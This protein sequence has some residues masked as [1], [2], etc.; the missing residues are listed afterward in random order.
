MIAIGARGGP[1]TSS[2]GEQ[3]MSDM[4]TIAVI[5][6]T[7]AQGGGLVR[8]ILGDPARRFA[9]RAITRNTDSEKAG[10]LHAAG[11]EVVGGDA[12]DPASLERAF[13]GAYGAFLVTNLWEQF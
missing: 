12:D 7:G 6:S 11:A 2:E 1:R 8:A 10:A 9:V 5:G 3:R 4:K 13:A